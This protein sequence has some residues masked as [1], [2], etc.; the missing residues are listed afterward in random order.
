[1]RAVCVLEL[2]DTI[3]EVPIL[4]AQTLGAQQAIESAALRME[5]NCSSTEMVP[6]HQ[7]VLCHTSYKLNFDISCT[8]TNSNSTSIPIYHHTTTLTACLS[9]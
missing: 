4:R 9:L 2:Q 8:C 3:L 7:T 5:T 1:M 6:M